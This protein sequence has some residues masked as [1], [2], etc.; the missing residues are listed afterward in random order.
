[1]SFREWSQLTTVSDEENPHC[2]VTVSAL[3]ALRRDPPWQDA[4]FLKTNW[5]ENVRPVEPGA[6]GSKVST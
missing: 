3:L 6:S 5:H 1:M 4:L 2:T